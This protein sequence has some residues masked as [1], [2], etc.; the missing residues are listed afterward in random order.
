MQNGVSRTRLDPGADRFQTLRRELGVTAFGL[1]H[2]LLAPGQR[3]RIHR[4]ERQEEVFLVLEGVLTLVI[5]GEPVDLGPGEL[6]RVAP[7]VRRQLV[8]GTTAPVRLIAVGAAGAHEGRDGLAYVAWADAEGRPV[9]E[10]PLPAD[11]PA[12]GLRRA[13]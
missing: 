4:H 10:V 3:G 6:A 2:L 8:N 11:L 5:E 7:E 12:A 13:P 9:P 1:N